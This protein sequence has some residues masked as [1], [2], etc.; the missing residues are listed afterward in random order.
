MGGGIGHGGGWVGWG[1]QSSGFW[2]A[3][4]WRNY[5][6]GHRAGQPAH[7]N[8]PLAP[9]PFTPSSTGMEHVEP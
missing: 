9:L 5:H 8:P 6:P 7:S 4:G 1:S 3:Q 2:V